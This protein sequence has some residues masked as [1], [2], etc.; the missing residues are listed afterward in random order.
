MGGGYLV[1]TNLL[2]WAW[3]EPHRIPKRYVELFSGEG[4]FYVSVASIWEIA[5]KVSVGKLVTVPDV[6]EAIISS[7]YGI[8]PVLA[9]HAEAVRDLPFYH[10]DPFD[11]MIIAQAKVEGM[12]LAAMDRRFQRYDVALV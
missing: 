4:D 1:D 3:H 5:V 2:V 8:V 9:E 12:T 10:R 11:R 6:T 7:G